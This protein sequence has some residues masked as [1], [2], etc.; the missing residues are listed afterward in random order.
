MSA[1]EQ[2]DWADASADDAPLPDAA[3]T[4]PAGPREPSA[5]EPDITESEPGGATAAALRIEEIDLAGVQTPAVLAADA[6][7][8]SARAAHRKAILA[9]E[10]ARD[11]VADAEGAERVAVAKAEDYAADPDKAEWQRLGATEAVTKAGRALARRLAAVTAQEGAVADAAAAAH[12]AAFEL[13]LAVQEARAEIAAAQAADAADVQ[14]DAEAQLYYGSVDEFVREHLRFVYRRQIDG[15]R[16]YWAAKWWEHDEAVQRLEA[17]WRSWE[18]LRQDPSTGMSVWW[19]DHADH[20]MAVLMSSAGPFNTGST[21][22][23]DENKCGR[24]E[25]LPYS[26][27]PAGLFSDVRHAEAV[28]GDR[29]EPPTA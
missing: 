21:A 24:G 26:P 18:H 22:Y 9:L 4:V 12:S 25:P 20:H 6:E 2:D 17:L 16:T 27:P 5:A 19:R 29:A 3:D 15:S 28:Q 1:P 13:R 23:D 7:L 11:A 14:E 10:A 8:K